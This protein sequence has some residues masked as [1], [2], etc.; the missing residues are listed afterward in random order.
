[1]Q[2]GE[3][4][5]KCGEKVRKCDKLFICA[6]V[7]RNHMMS[8]TGEELNFCAEYNKPFNPAQNLKIHMTYSKC[9]KAAPLCTVP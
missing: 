6:H 5:H 3:K 1:M 8:H 7:L 9:S 2:S 4:L